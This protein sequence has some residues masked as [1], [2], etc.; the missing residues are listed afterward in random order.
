MSLVPRRNPRFRNSS[1]ALHVRRGRGPRLR[2]VC[3]AASMPRERSP[4]AGA[5]EYP[6]SSARAHPPSPRDCAP[7]IAAWT[8]LDH[9][10]NQIRLLCVAI[11]L[12]KVRTGSDTDDGST[13]KTSR[14]APPIRCS[15]NAAS[16]GSRWTI[17]AR[18][19][20]TKNPVGFMREMPLLRKKNVWSIR[21]KLQVGGRPQDLAI[22]N[23][24][25]D[26]EG[27]VADLPSG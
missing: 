8:T 9:M 12:G 7:M 3:A 2:L 20:L 27:L 6:R 22:F 23:L 24:A 1:C 25:I 14:P 4:R 21:S 11:T 5:Q 10:E 26:T 16:N 17:S 13:S 19:V 18:E 15:R